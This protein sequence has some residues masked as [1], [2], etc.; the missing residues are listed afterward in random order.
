MKVRNAIAS[1]D[2]E[3]NLDRGFYNMSYVM[4]LLNDRLAKWA[5]D[6]HLNTTKTSLMLVTQMESINLNDIYLTLSYFDGE[7][8]HVIPAGY[9]GQALTDKEV[10][11]TKDMPMYRTRD[12]IRKPPYEII[13][14]SRLKELEDKSGIVHEVGM[15][16]HN[17]MTE[18]CD[19][20]DGIRAKLACGNGNAF[21]FIQD[22]QKVVTK[23]EFYLKDISLFLKKIDDER[24]SSIRHSIK[25]LVGKGKKIHEQHCN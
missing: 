15:A 5:K 12:L 3:T 1:A 7:Q 9:V 8:E 2:V 6:H 19:V 4:L 23:M 25:D 22:N 24:T 18:T 11:L 20:G 21:L 10:T 16:L 13:Q 17:F 14:T